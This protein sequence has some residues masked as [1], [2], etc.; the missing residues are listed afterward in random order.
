VAIVVATKTKKRLNVS[1]VM[2]RITILLLV[3]LLGNAVGLFAKGEKLITL[4]DIFKHGTFNVK[5]V[6]GF[7]VLNNGKHYTKVETI[8]GGSTVIRVYD[9]ASGNL[10]KT[11]FNNAEQTFQGNELQLV[12]YAFSSDEQKMLL[13]T[14]PQNIYRRSVLY[15]VYVYDIGTKTVTLLDQQMVLHATFNAGAD[16]VA[17]VKDN[18]LFVKDLKDG[19]LTQ[20]TTDGKRNEIINGNCDWVYEEEFEF[21]QAYQWS[22]DGSY[23]AYYRFDESKVPEYTMAIYDSLYPTQYTF[24]YPKAGDQNSVVSIH[25]FDVRTGAKTMADIGAETDQYIPRI[26][27]ANDSELCIFRLNRLQNKLEYL[28]TSAV[29]GK[30]SVI[31]TES[32]KYY[33]EINDNLTFLSDKQSFVF[34]SERDGYNHLYKWNWK[35]QELTQLTKG[36]WNVDA[37]IGV[38]ERKK[39]IYF[40]AGIASPLERKLYR[41]ALDGA[42]QTCITPK[43]GW[44]DIMPCTG[45]NFFLDRHST[46]TSVPVY[47]LIQANGRVV[48]VLE[49]NAALADVLANYKLGELKT[50]ML[51]GANKDWLNAWI[52]TPP[53]FDSTVKYPVLMYQYSGPGS[54]EVKDRFPLGNYFWHQMMAQKGYIVVCVD[55]TG[56][57]GRSELFKKKTY[58]QLGNLESND[59]IAVARYLTGLPFVDQQRIG[60]W[61]WSYGGFMSATCILKANDLF[62][63]AVSV[64][65]VTNWRYYDNIYTE[66]YMR[67]P[68]EN[69][70]G[71]DENAPEK[72]AASLK[73]NLLIIH[74]TAD[75]NV[76]FQNAVMLT[77][78]LIKANKQFE[79][80][81]YPNKNHGIG[82]GTT[83]LQL[84]GKITQYI[85]DKL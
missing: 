26:K 36:S 17:Y 70:A 38:D 7:N 40:T 84:F 61:G 3:A 67:T 8:A 68:Q 50:W 12:D 20:V 2:K 13:F 48:R 73:G 79:S 85:L 77:N 5:N 69:A 46:M 53:D 23:L 32:S 47:S 4:E 75:D 41:I 31:L 16:K 18:N 11:L 22:P 24:K 56:T 80:I 72:M 29:S 19:R 58:L 10:I 33:M 60:I 54:Q 28:L 81:Y 39:S 62:K 45:F 83:R 71:Y 64:A 21:T 44:H 6:P 65:P 49:D 78:E 1:F 66:R 51:P 76:H 9:L 35:K 15:V 34:N 74:G 27:W 43:D 82:G 59:Q 57:G 42:E 52:I 30:S 14:E 63:T 37:M 25:F 55:G